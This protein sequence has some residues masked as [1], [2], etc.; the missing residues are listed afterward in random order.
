[1]ELETLRRV[2]RPDRFRRIGG[3][4][5]RRRHVGQRPAIRASELE[6]AVTQPLDLVVLF[7][8]RPVMS[9]T[10]QREIR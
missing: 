4:R 7:V 5:R 6:G 1:M 9:A 8:Q 2:L 10:E 3:H